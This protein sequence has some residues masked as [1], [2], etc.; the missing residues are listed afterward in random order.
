MIVD[1]ETIDGYRSYQTS[2][3]VKTIS[4][5]FCLSEPVNPNTGTP[6]PD[7]VFKF[8]HHT[9]FRFNRNREG[10][11]TSRPEVVGNYDV[12]P[13]EFKDLAD[14]SSEDIVNLSP[15]CIGVVSA[16]LYVKM[17]SSAAGLIVGIM[18]YVFYNWLNIKIGADG[19]QDGA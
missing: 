8:S 2:C 3:R 13:T 19:K 10:N 7:A 1:S 15:Q 17:I 18:A 6:N 12:V 16:G 9:R 5:G 4:T 11:Y 14:G